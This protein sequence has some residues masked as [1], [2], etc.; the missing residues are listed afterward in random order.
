MGNWYKRACTVGTGSGQRDEEKESDKR[1]L[2][3]ENTKRIQPGSQPLFDVREPA[4]VPS[5]RA[6]S[7]E[8]Y[9]PGNGKEM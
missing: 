4:R 8:I 3:K 5:A 2:C 7:N 9:S 6:I 1:H